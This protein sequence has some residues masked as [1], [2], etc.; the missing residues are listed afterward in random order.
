[1][2]RAN[3]KRNLRKKRKTLIA[4]LKLDLLDIYGWTPSQLASQFGNAEAEGY[5]RNPLRKTTLRPTKWIT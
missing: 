2:Q 5:I 1:M 3:L 4:C